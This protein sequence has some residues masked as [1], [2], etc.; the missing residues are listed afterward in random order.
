MFAATTLKKGKTWDRDTDDFWPIEFGNLRDLPRQHYMGKKARYFELPFWDPETTFFARLNQDNP[1]PDEDARIAALIYL[2]GTVRL[3]DKK[4]KYLFTTSLQRSQ[5][6]NSS[7]NS[8][9]GNQKSLLPQL[10][11]DFEC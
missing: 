7:R 5:E 11:K 8:S 10:G 9:L 1:A 4:C 6:H 2:C 3:G